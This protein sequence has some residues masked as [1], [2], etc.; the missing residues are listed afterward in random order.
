MSAPGTDKPVNATQRSPREDF[1]DELSNP[2]ANTDGRTGAG[3]G[4]ATPSE[5]GVDAATSR[6]GDQSGT[7]RDGD[8]EIEDDGPQPS[9]KR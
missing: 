1:G 7:S 2:G 4:P 8:H 6:D 3:A 9:K 5:A